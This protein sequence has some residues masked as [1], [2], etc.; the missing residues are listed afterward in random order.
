M[1]AIG[2]DQG[3]WDLHGLARGQ[4]PREIATAKRSWGTQKG[5]GEQLGVQ[6]LN[7]RT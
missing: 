3:R 2:N 6:F 4:G 1:I 5:A 7:M